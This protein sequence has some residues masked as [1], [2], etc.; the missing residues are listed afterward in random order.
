MPRG[1]PVQFEA[2]R[3]EGLLS[4]TEAAR[5]ARVDYTTIARLIRRGT[6][7]AERH[8]AHRFIRVADLVQVYG[9]A[10]RS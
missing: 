10:V 6:L 4:L 8:G 9:E 1:N 2:L 3:Q 7:A 5:R